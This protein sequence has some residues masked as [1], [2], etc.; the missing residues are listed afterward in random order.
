MSH[1]NKI[2]SPFTKKNEYP[3]SDSEFTVNLQKIP[4]NTTRFVQ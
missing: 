2:F 3:L 4:N 1:K